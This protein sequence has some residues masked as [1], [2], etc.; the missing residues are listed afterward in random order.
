MLLLS[1]SGHLSEA[2]ELAVGVQGVAIPVRGNEFRPL[3]RERG[4]FADERAVDGIEFLRIDQR[5]VP[6]VLDYG[7]TEA[8][9]QEQR[10]QIGAV[11]EQ[12]RRGLVIV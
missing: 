7:R 10:Q 4:S 5:V 1:A 6:D 2:V 9:L 12:R 11:A 3:L 8:R